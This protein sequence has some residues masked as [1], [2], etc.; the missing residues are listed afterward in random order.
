MRD[1]RTAAVPLVLETPQKF[2]EPDREDATADPYDIAMLALLRG[3]EAES[4][5][6]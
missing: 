3:L 5:G 6:S 4:G 1:P 2:P